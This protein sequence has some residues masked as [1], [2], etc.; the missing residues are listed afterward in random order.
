MQA[1]WHQVNVVHGFIFAGIG[2]IAHFNPTQP[3]DRAHAL[4]TG[5]E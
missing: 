4:R 3:F 1:A 5:Y 2:L